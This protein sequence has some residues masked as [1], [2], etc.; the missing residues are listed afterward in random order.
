MKYSSSLV[1]TLLIGVLAVPVAVSAKAPQP[2]YFTL[3]DASKSEALYELRTFG[4]SAWYRCT[5]SNLGCEGIDQKDASLLP[6]ELQDAASRH[7]S[8]DN[9]LAVISTFIPYQG[10]R[11]VLYSVR[12]DDLAQIAVLPITND[13]SRVRFSGDGSVL[14]ITEIG[15]ATMR[16]DVGSGNKTVLTSMLSGGSWVSLSPDGNYAAYY[17]P[18]TASKE[19]RTF[20]VVDTKLDKNYLYTEPVAYWDLLT[21]GTTLFAFSPDSKKLLYLSD[22]GGYPTLYEVMLSALPI[23]G[24][25]GNPII[26]RP[27]SVSEFIWTDNET[28]LFSANR[29]AAHAWDLYRYNLTTGALT[30][31]GDDISYDSAFFRSGNHVL[32]TQIQGAARKPVAYSITTGTL[33]PF[34]IEGFEAPGVAIIEG[35]EVT[36]GN[37][38]GVWL[39]PSEPTKTLIVWLH[40]GPYRQASAGYHPYFSYAGYDWLLENLRSE[41]TAVL[42]LDY[43]GSAG[44][45]R[46]FAESITGEV[47]VVDVAESL[48]AIRAFAGAHGYTDVR[49]LGNS[50]GGYLALKL[51]AEHPEDFSGAFSINGVTDWDTLTRNLQTS[52]FNVQFN[53]VRSDANAALYD[54]ASILNNLKSF[55]NKDVVLAHGDADMT[56]P[57]AQ[58]RLLSEQLEAEDIPVEFITYEGEDHVYG[59][60][61]TFTSLCQSVFSFAQNN[62]DSSCKL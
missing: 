44:Y 10:S 43:P 42:K 36:A 8:P 38:Q 1:A 24:I 23:S 25:R 33:L 30:H 11:H 37:L 61:E 13:I 9:S 14:L 18:A 49:L 29:E 4:D 51:L 3:L 62:Q 6:T 53:G 28:V 20:G 22:R 39:K 45:G 58:S 54:N 47:G 48:A 55:G 56:V 21:E 40:G 46:P 15:G 59:N 26:T 19:E 50:Y 52:I 35:E 12:G 57:Y 2:E 16:Y 31:I 7:V 41:G 27:Y 34:T 5:L 17:I 60:P 32:L